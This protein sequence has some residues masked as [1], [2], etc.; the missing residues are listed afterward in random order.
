MKYTRITKRVGRKIGLPNF[1]S[2]TFETE[3]SATIEGETLEEA[4]QKIWEDCNKCL[5]RDIERW[6]EKIKHG[7]SKTKEQEKA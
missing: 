1:S 7:S 4:N 3:L 6:K 5:A 2:V